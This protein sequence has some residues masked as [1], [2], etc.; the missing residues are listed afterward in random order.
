MIRPI[1]MLVPVVF[2]A[3]CSAGSPFILEATTDTV[4]V[5][6]QAYPAISEPVL[7]VKGPLP[8]AVKYEVVAQ[9]TYGQPFYGGA[10]DAFLALANQARAL[11]CDAVIEVDHWFSPAGWGWATPHAQGKAVRITNRESAGDLSA[12]GRIF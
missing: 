2:L 1:F 8:Q 6:D 5:A 12:L 10:D 3:A 11:G 7:V 9:L 4:M